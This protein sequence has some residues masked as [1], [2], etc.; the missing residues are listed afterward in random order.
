[1]RRAFTIVL[2]VLA[3]STLTAAVG[4]AQGHVDPPYLQIQSAEKPITVDGKLD[5]TDWQRRFDHLVFRPNFTPGDV[6]YAVTGGT[7]VQGPYTDTTTTIVKI[8]HYGLDLYISLQSDDRSVC[9]FD[10][11][12]EGDGLFMKIADANGIPVEYK[13]YF[14]RSGH[15]PE[16]HYEEPGM[17]PGSGQGAAWK[18]PGTVVNDTTAPDSGYTA[19]LVIHL[20]Q[21]GYT[22]PYADVP[23]LINIFDPDGYTGEDG[24][25]WSVG[26]YHKMWWGSEWGPEMR[27]LRLADPPQKIAIKTD[28]D[29]TLDGKLDESFWANADSVVIMK[30]SH[31]STAG[32]YMQW[33]NPNNQYDDVSRAVV[34]FAHKGTDLYIGVTSNDSSVC[35]WSPGWEADG[36]FLWMTMKGII[37]GPA[38]RMEI[39]A[40][41]FDATQGAGISF[42]TNANVPT[43]GAEGASYEPPGTVTHTETNGPDAGYSL[44]VVV[45]TDLFGYSEGDT[46]MLSAVIWDMDYASADAY[47]PDK[48]DYAPNWWGTQWADVNFEKYYLYRGVVLSDKTSLGTPMINVDVRGV[49]FGE[50]TVNTK[51]NKTVT[52]SNDG[53]GTL[54]VTNVTSDNSAFTV[55]KTSFNVPP[56][57]STPLKISFLPTEAKNYSGTITIESN[58]GNVDITVSGV[59]KEAQVQPKP[60]HV[61][62]A[63]IQVQTAEHPIVI[64]GKLDETDWQRRFD[65]LIFRPNFQPGDVEYAVTGG[66]TVQGP[67]TDTTTTIVKFLHRGTDLYISLQSDDRSVCRFDGSWEGD[68]M[69]MK[70]KDANGN[71]LEYKFYFNLGGQDPGIH[72][73]T[74]AT[75]PNSAEGAAWKR[76]GTVVNDTTAPDSGYTAELVIHL[77][78]LGYT[79]PYADV[80]VLINIFDPDGYTGEDGQAWSVGAYHKMWWGSEWGPDMRVLRLADPPLKVAVKTDDDLTLDGKLDES[81][82]AKA[83]SIV[84]MKGSHSSTAGWYMQW[85]NPKNQ[86]TDT[87]RAVIKFA[88]KGA[89]LYIGMVS[90]DQSVCKWSPGWE[91]DGLFIWMT[92]KGI[93]PDPGDRMEIKAMY[94]NDSTGAGIHFE[95]NANVPT[96]AAEGVSYEPPGTVTHTESNGPDAGY[97]LEVLIHTDYFGYAE[98]DTVKISMVVWDMDYASSDAFDPD[99]SDYAPNWWGTQWV[100]KNFEK[101]YLYRDLVLSP[102]YT[103]GV[104]DRST[105]GVVT[106]YRLGQNYPNPF[107][108]S[109]RIAFELPEQTRVTVEV[110]DVL[111][112]KVATLVNAKNYSAG[113]HTVVWNGRDDQGHLMT[114]GVYFYRITTP[115]FSQTKKMVLMK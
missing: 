114:S 35:K 70:I 93:I 45:H 64:D 22:D 44:E 52:I 26:A 78:Q 13:L 57:G 55:D 38:D 80:P 39:K 94:F 75:L 11:S 42:E 56:G 2:A 97:S 73:E 68:G 3:L 115:G 48:S 100:D 98:G 108:P 58:A 59:G 86:Y 109:T 43:G 27:I 32:W 95:T 41:Y 18:R 23:V 34:R 54:L 20:D 105:A 84:I 4:L 16:V 92:Y 8:L 25:A 30:G 47:D 106:D 107:N 113:R 103:V 88:H 31:L 91:A 33:G 102:D 77:D 36:L 51:A 74:P 83:D 29:I 17:Y 9:R 37:P 63:Y 79:D 15:D 50:V 110:Y 112:K 71:V 19:E 111:G 67:Y 53:D 99:I 40:M 62:P 76:P 21:L 5:E 12:W 60:G 87:S 96:G 66:T 14:N 46:V 7:T 72:L 90:N 6:E 81:F 82:W 10:G 61:D 69:F 85:G 104:E 49:D 28:Q 89:D 1:M 101:Y 24:Q 65:H